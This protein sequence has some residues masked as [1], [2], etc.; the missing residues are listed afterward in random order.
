MKNNFDVPQVLEG[1]FYPQALEKGL[2][3]ERA[4]KLTL[5]VLANDGMVPIFLGGDHSVSLPLLRAVA[6]KQG[7]VALVHFDSHSDLWHG[8]FGGKDT[9][10]TPFRT[11]IAERIIQSV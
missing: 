10:G 11:D 5:K 6:E 1:G 2:R 9:H 3:S 7:P 4:L 8:Y